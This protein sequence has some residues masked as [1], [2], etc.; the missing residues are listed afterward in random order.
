MLMPPYRAA[1]IATG[2]LALAAAGL[3]VAAIFG[4]HVDLLATGTG[5]ATLVALVVAVNL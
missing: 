3:I 1:W 5:V 4:V 2:L